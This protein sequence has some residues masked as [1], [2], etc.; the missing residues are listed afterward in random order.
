[1]MLLRRLSTNTV[2]DMYWNYFVIVSHITSNA[3][4]DSTSNYEATNALPSRRRDTHF[5]D[6]GR[7]ISNPENVNALSS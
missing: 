4:T 7:H 2:E 3:S 6:R 5:H 1:M